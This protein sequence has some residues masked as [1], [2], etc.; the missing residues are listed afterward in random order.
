MTR[1]PTAID[2]STDPPTSPTQSETG[3]HL[4]SSI[5]IMS[6]NLSFQ[7]EAPVS[8]SA[9][10]GA[11]RC[12]RHTNSWTPDFGPVQRRQSWSAEDRKHQLHMEKIDHVAT[13]PGFSEGQGA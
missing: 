2:T 3:H 8:P 10:A 4:H 1:Q 9:Q 5:I 7:Q 12:M 6:A 11:D 13:G